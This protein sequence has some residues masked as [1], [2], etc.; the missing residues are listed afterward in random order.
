GHWIDT[1]LMVVPG[2]MHEKGTIG[3]LEIGTTIGFIGMFIFT[4]F[5]ALT[6]LSLL[7]QKHPMLQ[8]SEHFIL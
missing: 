1:Y 6:K 2:I 5:T 3:V 8:E 4:V 7:P